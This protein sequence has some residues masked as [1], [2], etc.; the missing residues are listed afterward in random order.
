MA[1][2]A[3]AMTK[4]VPAAVATEATRLRAVTGEIAPATAVLL[5]ATVTEA[6][7]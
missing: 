5:A 3:T 4:A 7:T 2:P 6:V 1:A